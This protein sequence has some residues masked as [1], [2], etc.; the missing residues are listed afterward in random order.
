MW[1][2]VKHPNIYEMRVPEGNEGKEKEK[3][4][5][6]ETVTKI[7]PNLIKNNLQILEAPCIPHSRNNRIHT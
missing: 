3:H 7:F 6:G 1:D 5:C 2:N 4:I